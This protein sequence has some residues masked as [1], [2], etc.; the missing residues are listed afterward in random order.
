MGAFPRLPRI[1]SGPAVRLAVALALGAGLALPTAA[2]AITVEA[3]LWYPGAS[4]PLYLSATSPL[5]VNYSNITYGTYTI[6]SLVG[7]L[8]DSTANIW[9][10]HFTADFSSPTTTPLAVVLSASGVPAAAGYFIGTDT[11]NFLYKPGTAATYEATYTPGGALFSHQDSI[12]SDS[13][14]ST[15]AVRSWSPYPSFH[16]GFVDI[17]PAYAMTETFVV[18]PKAGASPQ[19]TGDLLFVPEPASIALLLVGIGGTLLVA[20]RRR[21]D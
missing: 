18:T 11:E 2:S 10:L 15:N 8:N 7:Y 14:T 5:T 12:Y 20:R 4:A 6:H 21:V 16:S 13:F 1:P 3:E 17:S 19:L 9:D